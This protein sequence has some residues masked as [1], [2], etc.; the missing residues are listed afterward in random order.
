MTRDIATILP[1]ITSFDI[2]SHTGRNLSDV[3]TQCAKDWTVI[4][5]VATAIGGILQ[6][7]N[8]LVQIDSLN[9]TKTTLEGLERIS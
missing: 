3:I 9:V 6:G 4:R 1:L 2:G 7:V 5:S 8:F